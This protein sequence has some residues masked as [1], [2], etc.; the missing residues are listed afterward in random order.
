LPTPTRRLTNASGR[1]I[2]CSI[3][4]VNAGGQ[5]V[6]ADRPPRAGAAQQRLDRTAVRAALE[7]RRV[8]VD[9]HQRAR[10]NAG[11]PD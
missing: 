6:V 1:W 9:S 11:G 4:F 2:A 5:F 3:V 10:V 8:D 7:V